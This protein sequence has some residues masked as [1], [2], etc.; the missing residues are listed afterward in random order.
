MG[1]PDISWKK[2]T[3]SGPI[4]IALLIHVCFEMFCTGTF[5]HSHRGLTDITWSL[6]TSLELHNEDV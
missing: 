4:A 1:I 5:H 3:P 2:N 6:N